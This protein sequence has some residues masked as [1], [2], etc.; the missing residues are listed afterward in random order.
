[1][2]NFIDICARYM[3]AINTSIISNGEQY[4]VI[5]CNKW[6]GEKY[7]DCFQIAENLIDIIDENIRYTITPIYIEIN[8]DDL[9]I[10][11]FNIEK[12]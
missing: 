10:V 1:M 3:G 2:K 6:D 5:D 8:E 9:Y 7:F 12:C 4:F 11:D